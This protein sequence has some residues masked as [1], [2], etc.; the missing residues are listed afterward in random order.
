M[1]EYGA[2]A[3]TSAADASRQGTFAAPIPLV[4]VQSRRGRRQSECGRLRLGVSVV[5]ALCVAGGLL[6][7]LL[8]LPVRRQGDGRAELT[9]QWLADSDDDRG[10]QTSALPDTAGQGMRLPRLIN[11]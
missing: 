1:R 11:R 7:C 6:A 4:V 8:V 5:S 2:T 9:M 10:R 3:A